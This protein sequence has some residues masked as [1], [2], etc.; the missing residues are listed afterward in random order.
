MGRE[1]KK[2]G[3]RQ[4]DGAAS[5]PCPERTCHGGI[6][7][8][9]FATELAKIKTTL[10]KGTPA[11]TWLQEIGQKNR[12]TRRWA[13]GAGHI[14]RRPGTSAPN[15]PGFFGA[16]RPEFGKGADWS[17]PSAIPKPCRC[18][19]PGY[20]PPSRGPPRGYPKGSG[21]LAY[22]RQAGYSGQ[23]QHHRLT[24]QISRVDPG[25]EHLAFRTR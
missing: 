23:Y 7:K 2:L 5:P 11:E 25:P 9:S 10:A 4:S 14:H 3:L 12:I 16:I 1:L 13:R 20:R 15:R 8:R 17:C 19:W 24:G 22:D 21:W 18:I 6:Q